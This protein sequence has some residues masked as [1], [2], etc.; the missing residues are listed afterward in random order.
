MRSDLPRVG[1]PAATAAHGGGFVNGVLGVLGRT[2]Y[3]RIGSGEDLDAIYRLRYRSYLASDLIEPNR[4][5][6][7][8]D[9]LDD[10]PN[11][12]K[13]AVYVDEHLV[14]TVRIHHL[15]AEH[16][17]SP[18]M[19][20]FADILRP[21]LARGETFID[22]SRL[23]ADP[24]WAAVIPQ[25]PYIT[26]RLAVA[27]LEHFRDTSCLAMVRDEHCAFYRRYFSAERIAEPRVYPSVTVLG[28]LF[29]SN[30]ERNLLKTQERYPFFRSSPL[31][32]RQLFSDYGSGQPITIIPMIGGE[33]AAA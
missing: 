32:R 22:P 10:A 1:D 12:R 24:A 4:A 33:R 28:H 25:I 20:V 5:Q 30:R 13:F 31:E 7:F 19:S 21:R 18:A 17:F 11:C 3:R 26:L 14:S 6:A 29:E 23:A 15:T 9:T 27:A 8:R 16:P 2:E